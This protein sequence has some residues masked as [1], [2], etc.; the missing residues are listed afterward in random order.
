MDGNNAALYL[1]ANGNEGDI[2]VYDG[3]GREVFRFDSEFAALYIGADGNEGDIIV[4]DGSGR[5]VFHVDSNF[6][7]VY[8]G[9]NG[10]EGDVIVRNDNGD[11]TIRL[12]GGNGDIIL[13]NADAAEDFTLA[14]AAEAAPGTV[15]VLD[16]DGALAPCSTA[17]DRRV[18]GVVAGAGGFRPGIVLDRRDDAAGRRVPVSMVGKVSCLADARY[19]PIEAGDLLTSSPTTGCAMRAEDP[20]RASGAT[21]GKALTP[22]RQGRG[23][24][25][26]VISLQ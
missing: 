5:E 14:E 23:L 9:A 18:I 16:R 2:F 15:V 26:M 12:N 17:Y 7:A 11:E 6:A 22:L 4:R 24:V 8:V 19:G 10:N 20:L 13:T 3:A 25:D 1:G 21:I